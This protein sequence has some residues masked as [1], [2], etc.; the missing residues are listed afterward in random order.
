MNNIVIGILGS[1]LDHQGLGKR[2]HSRWRPSIGI[3]MHP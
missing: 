3:L 2:R 1:R